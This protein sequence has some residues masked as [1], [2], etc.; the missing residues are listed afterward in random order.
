MTATQFSSNGFWSSQVFTAK[1]LT[2]Q[3]QSRLRHYK[4]IAAESV[5]TV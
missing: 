5:I 3:Y 2:T 4:V 1:I